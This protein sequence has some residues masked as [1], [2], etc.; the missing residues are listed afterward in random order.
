MRSRHKIESYEDKKTTNRIATK[1]AKSQLKTDVATQMLEEQRDIDVV[2]S[3]CGRDINTEG[4]L[5]KRGRDHKRSRDHKS[6]LLQDKQV[7]T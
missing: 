1:K 4:T 2:T 7:A 3:T 6:K 5:S